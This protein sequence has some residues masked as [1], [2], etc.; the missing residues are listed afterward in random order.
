MDVE[1]ESSNYPSQ[2]G[3][4]RW[5]ARVEE[6]DGC[7]GVSRNRASAGWSLSSEGRKVFGLRSFAGSNAAGP[8]PGPTP[9][10]GNAH[11]HPNNHPNNNPPH[12]GDPTQNG[13]GAWVLVVFH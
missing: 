12:I 4:A 7:P 10:P 5:R 11:K 9:Q 13:S 6:Q 1:E 8:P 2:L 3:G